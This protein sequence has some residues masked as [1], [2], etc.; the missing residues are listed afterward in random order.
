MRSRL[1]SC[2]NSGAIVNVCG[3]YRCP[4][5]DRSLKVRVHPKLSDRWM[6]PQHKAI[7]PVKW[8]R[9]PFAKKEKRSNNV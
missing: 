7:E 1:D 2:A 9:N 8:Q 6:V 5:C 4:E 3:N